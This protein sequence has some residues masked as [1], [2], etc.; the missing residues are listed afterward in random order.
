MLAPAGWT[1]GGSVGSDGNMLLSISASGQSASQAADTL[2]VSAFI[3][4]A[5]LGP[6]I[7]LACPYFATAAAA[8][9]QR[10]LPCQT[11]PAGEIVHQGGA[12]FVEIQDPPGVSGLL[13]PSGG[14]Y[15]ANGVVVWEPS[16]EYS[17]QAV[18]TLP[19]QQHQICT[20]VL[21]D[22]LH[23]YAT[24]PSSGA[25][26]AATGA[27]A[28]TPT[29]TTS[30]APPATATTTAGSTPL[31][32]AGCTSGLYEP[33]QIRWCT[34]LCSSYMTNITWTS[35]TRSSATGYGTWMT[36]DGTPD[37]ARGTWTAHYDYPVSL[38]VPGP[39]GSYGTI[40]LDSNLYGPLPEFGC[41]G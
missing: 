29:P 14:D 28:T 6:A 39:C 27:T 2:G 3:A 36:N 38:S 9:S 40:F 17:A 32:T 10:G 12:N 13:S 33:R 24:P 31:F 34:S 25:N 23:R 4:S 11:R 18:C 8:A 37:C 16:T 30:V 7:Y 26:T 41:A 5:R 15:P 20:A 1:C 21:N 35:W 19:E 22:F